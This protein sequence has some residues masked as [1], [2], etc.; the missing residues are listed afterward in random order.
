MVV[1]SMTLQVMAN[2]TGP[3]KYLFEVS[4]DFV[5]ALLRFRRLQKSIQPNIQSQRDDKRHH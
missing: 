5:E 1:K 3:L 4:E 2:F